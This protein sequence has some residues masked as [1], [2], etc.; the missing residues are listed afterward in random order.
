MIELV[1]LG[2]SS[3]RHDGA[4]LSALAAHKQK[5]ALLSYLAVEGPVARSRL[6]TLFWPE[7][8]EEKARHSLSQLLYAL[9]KELDDE[10]VEVAGDRIRLL[11][12]TISV[13]VKEVEAA[14]QAERWEDVVELYGGPFLDQFYLPEAPGFEE[15]Q[16]RTRAWVG[17]L[18]RK[19]FAKVIASR[20]VAGDVTGALELAWR[21]TR[22]EPLEDEAQ[23]ALIA[24]LAMSGDRSAALAQFEAYRACLERE[25]EVEPLGVT[26]ALVEQ[27]RAGGFPQSPLLE[28]AFPAAPGKVAPG[29][30][31]RASLDVKAMPA[32]IVAAD[33]EQ[34]LRAELAPRLEIV[35]KLGESSTANVYLAC[36]PELKRMVAVKVFSP[37]LAS[38]RRARLRFERE[39]QAV[40]SLTH[41]NIAALH[42]AGS[43]SNGLP[44]FVMQYVE[45]PSM[46]DKLRLEGRLSNDQA[47]RLL[48][49]VASALA[50]AHRRG[51][52]HRDVQPANILCDEEAGRCLLADFGIS[53]ILATAEYRPV[54]ITESGELVG[55]PAWMSPEQLK[56]EEVSERSD[57][58]SLGLLG[59]QLL[60]E[61]SPYSTTTR[62]ELYAAH[63]NQQPRKLSELCPDVD[64]DLEEVLTRCLAKE[65]RRR[66]TASHVAR[67]LSAPPSETS[68]GG[69][70]P[71]FFARLTERRVPH[72]LGAYLAGGFGLFELLGVMVENDIV[73][74]LALQLAIA[75]FLV[76]IPAVLVL[77]WYHGR[78]GRQRFRLLEYWFLGVVVII[79]VVV[80]AAILIL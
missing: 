55:D 5:I 30:E 6:L 15:W 51:I 26:V 48:S 53:M 60:A 17:G 44:Y 18:A 24:L 49:Q 3:I 42:W 34:L 36:E 23:H 71:G 16:T 11:P 2:S 4:E 57:I 61:E 27:I 13:D 40:A 35:R 64:P 9:R 38:D 47:R 31:A 59:Y 68:R 12:G 72:W 37:K 65:P 54:K 14:G 79:W 29:L 70:P 50:S 19:A 25:L 77:A 74:R 62:Q 1:T 21:W 69:A 46:A 8:E 32:P 67:T 63:V 78:S 56:A 66:P 41:P 33:I 7:R 22:L 76:G 20:S 28:E 73:S 10:L 39:V 52:V 58:Y 80:L 45:G 43:L 75:S